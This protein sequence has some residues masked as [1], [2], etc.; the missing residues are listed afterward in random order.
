MTVVSQK[1][2]QALGGVFP[3]V[4]VIIVGLCGGALDLRWFDLI[5]DTKSQRGKQTVMLI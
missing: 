2:R 4:D 3:L 1:E 5:S